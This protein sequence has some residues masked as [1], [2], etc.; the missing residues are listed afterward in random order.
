MADQWTEQFEQTVDDCYLNMREAELLLSRV[1]EYPKTEDYMLMMDDD[2]VNGLLYMNEAGRCLSK[3]NSM[4]LMTVNGDRFDA[5]RRAMSLAMTVIEDLY[6]D[7]MAHYLST[8]SDGETDRHFNVDID[9]TTTLEEL[10][11]LF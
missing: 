9:L 5:I 1:T 10:S 2:R 8:V 4:S 3:C 7:A 11:E 6:D